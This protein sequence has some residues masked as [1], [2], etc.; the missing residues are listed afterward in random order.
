MYWNQH[1]YILSHLDD[2]S[3]VK[4]RIHQLRC[5]AHK[6]LLS[7]VSEVAPNDGKTVVDHYRP[8]A[9]PWKLPEDVLS[10]LPEF[11][12]ELLSKI[13]CKLF[14]TTAAEK[15]PEL[16][17]T[18]F[19]RAFLILWR[20]VKKEWDMLCEKMIGGLITLTE[21]ERIFRMFT[22]TDG[23]HNFGEI[24]DELS[25]IA[26]SRDKS[27][28]EDRITQFKLYTEIRQHVE[29]AH[30]MLQLK[31]VYQMSRGFKYIEQIF[32]PVSI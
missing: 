5:D 17:S 20:D 16:M 13:F 2:A 9:N 31:E 24:S 1:T 32:N 27:W 10:V 8:K 3:E 15:Q 30:V 6:H 11:E 14:S 22:D 18:T 28:V 12:R 23:S 29:A 25:K 26:D 19:W 7:D 21:T 4:K